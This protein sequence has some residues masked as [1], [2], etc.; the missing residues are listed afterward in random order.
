MGFTVETGI[1]AAAV[2]VQGLLSFFHPAYFL[3]CRCIWDIWPE[4][5]IWYQTPE[6]LWI[7]LPAAPLRLETGIY[8]E[9]AEE[10]CACFC[11][12]FALRLA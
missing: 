1:S 11:A 10:G 5:L 9:K 7:Y 2:F 8:V 3:L 12:Y 4:G 6:K